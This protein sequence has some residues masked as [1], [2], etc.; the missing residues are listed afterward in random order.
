ME[1]LS[2]LTDTSSRELCLPP[3]CSSWDPLPTSFCPG[4]L[5]IVGCFTSPEPLPTSTTNS[6]PTV[7]IA[8]HTPS[9]AATTAHSNTLQPSSVHTSPTSMHGQP[10][11]SPTTSMSTSANNV[12]PCPASTG[13]STPTAAPS[14]IYDHKIPIIVAVC[15]STAFIL[16]IA[17]IFII[18]HSRKIQHIQR[19]RTQRD[20]QSSFNSR[21]R[22]INSPVGSIRQV[23][24]QLSRRGL[25]IV[26]AERSADMEQ[27]MTALHAY[28]QQLSGQFEH[29]QRQLV[30]TNGAQGVSDDEEP[31]AYVQL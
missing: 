24:E 29:L 5:G 8:A 6:P 11:H 13:Y 30:H 23:M 19:Q 22:E 15:I 3:Q 21:T 25:R 16:T 28:V 17:I 20:Q 9:S 31:P 14:Q 12:R 1:P 18:R 4:A 10:T 7:S 2:Q 27:R 26:P